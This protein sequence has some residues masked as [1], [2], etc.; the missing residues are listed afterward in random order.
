PLMGARA[1][2]NGENKLMG[3]SYNSGKGWK[4]LCGGETSK[5]L[6]SPLEPG[7][8]HQVA[9][10]LRNGS[11]GSAYVDGKR[12]DGVPC[13]LEVTDSNGIS[14]FYIGGD[15]GSAE[16]KESRGVVP[17]TVTNVLLY[18]RPLTFSGGS[19]EEEK[20][21]AS[22]ADAAS[23]TAA[24]GQKTTAG[25]SATAQQLPPSPSEGSEGRAADSNSHAVEGA[26]GDGGSVRES[27][28][29]LPS[30]LLL[31]LGLWGFA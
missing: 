3:L 22:P 25:E 5:E 16:E 27:G 4:L 11:Q 21:V 24:G 2:S 29:A 15:G 18:N 9:I 10:V 26:T 6:S 28:M 30:L 12:V 7:K 17:V 13:E 23:H 20:D 1:G 14:H 8:Q 19:A 31:L